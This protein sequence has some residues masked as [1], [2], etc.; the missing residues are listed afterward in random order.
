MTTKTIS[1][2]FLDFDANN[3]MVYELFKKF[4]YQLVR[5]GRTRYS[6]D[7]ILH[8]VRWETALKTVGENYKINDHYSALYAR[9]LMEDDTNFEGFFETRVR[10]AG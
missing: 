5:A 10:R 7:A 9:K 1:E 2:R 6:A 4:A 8:R 3:P